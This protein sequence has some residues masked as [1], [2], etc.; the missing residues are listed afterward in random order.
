VPNPDPDGVWFHVDLHD[1]GSAAQIHTQPV[2][3][4]LRFGDKRVML[5]VLDGAR[6]E[7]LAGVLRQLLLDHGVRPAGP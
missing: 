7:G 5:L 3:E 2:V 1:P 4:E 6:T